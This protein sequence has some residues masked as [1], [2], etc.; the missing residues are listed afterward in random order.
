M[1]IQRLLGK[2]LSDIRLNPPQESL[3]L[4]KERISEKNTKSDETLVKHNLLPAAIVGTAIG[5][6]LLTVFNPLKSK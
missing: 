6:L 3:D 4:F 2:P 5:V 1:S